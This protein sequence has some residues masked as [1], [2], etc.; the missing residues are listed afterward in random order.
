M[1][2]I[3]G[4]V[5]MAKYIGITDDIDSFKVRVTKGIFNSSTMNGRLDHGTFYRAYVTGGADSDLPNV[6]IYAMLLTPATDVADCEFGLGRL[7]VLRGFSCLHADSDVRFEY[8]ENLPEPSRIVFDDNNGFMASYWVTPR[9]I[10]NQLHAEVPNISCNFE[11]SVAITDATF[12]VFKEHALKAFKE[13]RTRFWPWLIKRGKLF[14]S[15]DRDEPSDDTPRFEIASN[16]PYFNLAP[17]S[18]NAESVLDV[19]RLTGTAKAM[20]MHFSNIGLMK[21][22]ATS[23]LGQYIYVF[24]GSS[25][26]IWEWD[27]AD[28]WPGHLV[29][30][31]ESRDHPCMYA[32]WD[33][34]AE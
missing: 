25:A 4:L 29:A 13:E 7:N 16:V 19:L 22:E 23:E 26:R 11:L 24:L 5:D 28:D 1:R 27:R 17:Y 12:S 20:S 34:E 2:A 8:Q 18:Y 14:L 15:L 21:I 32:D 33:P 10:A 30:D 31:A 3:D 9:E 6:I